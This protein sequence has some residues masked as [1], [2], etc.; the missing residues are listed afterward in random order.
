MGADGGDDEAGH[1]GRHYAGAGSCGVGRTARRSSHYH[2]CGRV[3]N[4]RDG[5]SDLISHET[6]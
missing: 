1:G 5:D 2:T 3:A 6:V 4:S